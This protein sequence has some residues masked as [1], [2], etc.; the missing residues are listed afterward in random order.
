MLKSVYLWSDFRR[1]R[2]NLTVQ[3]LA[4]QRKALLLFPPSFKIGEVG[5]GRKEGVPPLTG[6][7]FWFKWD[8]VKT[9]EM[10][11]RQRALSRQVLESCL[12]P[13]LSDWADSGKGKSPPEHA[14]QPL[15]RPD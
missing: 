10:E 8:G 11:S 7:S 14:A 3:V 13:L 5:N 2:C 4:T 15:I 12:R 6:L 1:H 9:P